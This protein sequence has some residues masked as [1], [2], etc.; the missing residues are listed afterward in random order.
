MISIFKITYFQPWSK[1]MHHLILTFFA[2]R[3]CPVGTTNKID[4]SW[5]RN[6]NPSKE[7]MIESQS[8]HA[9]NRQSSHL[10]IIVI[11]RQSRNMAFRQAFERLGLWQRI[12]NPQVKIK[13]S[14]EQVK[15][16]R[17]ALHFVQPRHCFGITGWALI[18]CNRTWRQCPLTRIWVISSIVILLNF[19]PVTGRP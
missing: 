2:C 5:F 13:M 17:A 10:F 7:S 19:S 16:G 6:V 12:P 15:A 8:P 18:P 1:K 3:C 14:Q 9:L 11:G 4:I